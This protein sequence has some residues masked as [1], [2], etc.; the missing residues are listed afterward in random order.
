MKITTK[1][2]EE[3]WET[4]EKQAGVNP[5]DLKAILDQAIEANTLRAALEDIEDS[6]KACNYSVSI[7]RRALGTQEVKP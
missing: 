6:P 7:A 1:E 2:L 4:W 3:A 5:H